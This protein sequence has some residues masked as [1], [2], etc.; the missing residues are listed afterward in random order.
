M[1]VIT[2]GRQ[3]AK[4]TA[5]HALADLL[6]V[7]A[8]IAVV[9][10]VTVAIGNLESIGRV[11]AIG[12]AEHPAVVAPVVAV[13]MVGTV[14]AKALLGGELLETQPVAV[15]VKPFQTLPAAGSL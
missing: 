12:G 13:A 11:V 7:A 6:V 1:V 3:A 4:N 2:S 5:N 10:V 9:I 15:G 8:E 14:S